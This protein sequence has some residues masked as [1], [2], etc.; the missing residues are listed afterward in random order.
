MPAALHHHATVTWTRQDPEFSSGRYSRA[1]T[2]TFDGGLTLPASPSPQVVRPPWSDPAA[3]DPEEALVA[4]I[5]SC[6][7]LTFLYLAA[8]A[9]FTCDAYQDAAEGTMTRNEA[10]VWWVSAVVLRPQITWSGPS[11]PTPEQVAALH[12]QAHEQCFIAAS[13]RTAVRVEAI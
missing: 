5:A 9:G 3:I 4:A 13:V 7:L 11:R 10:G 12:E 1:H 6:H 8:G 2:W